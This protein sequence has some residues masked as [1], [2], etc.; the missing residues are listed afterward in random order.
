MEA[1]LDELK[2]RNVKG[3]MLTADSDNE[4]AIRFYERFGFK[5][6]IRS[7]KLN[8]IVMAKKLS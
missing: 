5:T 7:E 3:V 2:K 1:L 4:G 8:G 6:L